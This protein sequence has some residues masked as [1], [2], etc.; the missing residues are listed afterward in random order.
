MTSF[1]QMSGYLQLLDLPLEALCY[2]GCQ[3]NT[4]VDYLAYINSC[5]R[6]AQVDREIHIEKREQFKVWKIEY[7]T[8]KH[9][10][11]GYDVF[12]VAKYQIL[13]NGVKD[14]LYLEWEKY[15]EE[16]NKDWFDDRDIPNLELT[17]VNGKKEGL[18]INRICPHEEEVDTIR[19]VYYNDNKHGLQYNLSSNG[20]KHH[21]IIYENG[22]GIF[23]TKDQKTGIKRKVEYLNDILHGESIVW[24][25]DGQ[26]LSY[27]KYDYSWLVE[28]KIYNHDGILS[29][30]SYCDKRIRIKTY[31]TPQQEEAKEIITTNLETGEELVQDWTVNGQLLHEARYLNDIPHGL[32]QEWHNGVDQLR[33]RAN[34]DHG[35]VHGIYEQW[36]RDGSDYQ[37]YLFNN[38]NLIE[39][40]EDS[41]N[42]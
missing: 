9:E 24:N 11:E 31:Y 30:E 34:F 18:F 28:R 23:C 5:Q 36:D 19:G 6:L 35:N 15:Y 25:S 3:I 38:G 7:F 10:E 41:A 21:K 14:G 37:R 12:F 1:Q 17:Y 20:K 16:E 26:M 32:H 4:L 22:R 13:P 2:I 42:Q 40:Q 8:K 27:R 33:C 39:I 29:E